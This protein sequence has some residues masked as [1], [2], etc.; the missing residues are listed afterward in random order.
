MSKDSDI[1]KIGFDYRSSLEQFE[2]ETNGVFDEVSNRAG[3]Q[4]IV[5]QLDAKDDKLVE[6]IKELQ[7]LKLDKFTFEFG[8]SGLKEQLQTFDRLEG[9]I[10]EIIKLSK[11]NLKSAFNDVKN[12]ASLDGLSYGTDEYNNELKRVTSSIVEMGKKG[13]DSTRE[14]F[15]EVQKLLNLYELFRKRA[16]GN[17]FNKNMPQANKFNEFIKNSQ[18][19]NDLDPLKDTT[20]DIFNGCLVILD[21]FVD[22]STKKFLSLKDVI[23]KVISVGEELKSIADINVG[24]DNDINPIIDQQGNLQDE[25]KETETQAEKTSQAVKEVAAATTSTDQK[26][27]AFPDSSTNT[28]PETEGMEQVEK[29]TEEAVQAKKDFATANEGVQSSID[30]SE[31]PLKLEAELMDQIAKSARE[32]ADAKKEFVAAN[33]QVKEGA[34]DSTPALKNE[35]D[36]LENIESITPKTD[37]FDEI[38]QKLGI[39]K[40]RAEQ[41]E[42]IVENTQYSK[43]D[44]KSHTSYDI[45]YKGGYKETRGENSQT[46]RGNILKSSGVEY[47]SKAEAEAAKQELELKKKINDEIAEQTAA[48]QKKWQTFVQEQNDYE[49]SINQINIALSKTDDLLANLPVPKELEQIYSKLI[50][51]VELYNEKLKTGKIK[52]PEYNKNVNSLFSDYSKNVN[53]QQKRDVESYNTNAKEAYEKEKL[54]QAEKKLA[55]LKKE[56][57]KKEK[58][59][60]QSSVNKAL[61][62]QETAW[63]NIQDIR[64]KIANSNDNN[65]IEVLE[66]VKK[67]YQEQ[68]LA[69]SRIL[70]ANSDLYDKELQL[71]R[72]E[73][74]RLDTNKKLAVTN[75]N[76]EKIRRK[77]I[78][79]TDSASDKLKKAIKDNSYADASDIK[80][81]EDLIEKLNLGWANFDRK[82]DRSVPTLEQVNLTIKAIENKVDA[83]VSKLKT[84]SKFN[85]KALNNEIKQ[86]T[87][88]ENKNKKAVK[89]EWE[90]AVKA[91][92][93]YENA[94][95]K[96]NNLKAQDKGLGTKKEDIEAQQKKIKDMESSFEV[97]RNTILSFFSSIEKFNTLPTNSIKEVSDVLKLIG[98]AAQGS[99]ESVAHLESETRKMNENVISRHTDKLSS[100]LNKKDG[101]DATIAKFDNGGWTSPEYLKNVQAVKDAIREYEILLNKIKTDQN[102]IANEEDIQN[103]E[104]YKSQIEETIATVKNMSASEKGYTLLAGQKEIDKINKIL[105]ENSKMSRE[106]K[107][108]IKAY[109]QEIVSGNPSASLEKIHGEIMKIVNAEELAGR[110]GKSMLDTIGEKAWYGVASTIGTYFGINDIFRY[111]KQAVDVITEL[112]DALVD[113]KKT[114]TMS[115]TELNNFYYDSNDVA[116]QMGV[117]TEEII[118]QASAWSRLGYSSQE[119]ATTMAKLSSK[120]ASI[121]PGMS[122]DEAQEGLVSIMKAFDIDP[123]DVEA[124]IMD[125]VN[126]LGNK[127]AEENQDVIEGLK[128]SAAAMSAMGQSFTDTAALFTGGM[129]ILQ[130][131]ESMGTA[132]RTLSMRVRGYDEETEQLSDDLAN[133]TGEVADLTKTAKDSQ[134][135]SLFTDATQEHYRS[136]VEYLGDIADRWDQI[137]E[138][139]QTELLQKLFG[140][141]RANAGAAIIKNFDQVRAAIE[142]MYKSAG[143]SETEMSTIEKSISYKINA[144]KETWVGTVQELVDRGDIGK[145]V[146]GLTKISEVLGL[147]INNVGILGSVGLGAGI[148]AG[149]KN[150]GIDTLVAY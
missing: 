133:V 1:I 79:Y 143:S 53:I 55:A 100:Y 26:K 27:D 16:D 120:F 59:S 72:L 66:Q 91:V 121:S 13:H 6:K 116:K 147:I 128:R 145:I 22:V 112:D 146:D 39:A 44:K 71:A 123:D 85:E 139:N 109:K 42:K 34:D 113:L 38:V 90:D 56:N 47:D 144:L 114:T 70:K 60:Q 105:K 51:D 62:D 61:K 43:T 36:I 126:V 40:D 87:A 92:R 136:M 64:E 131:S 8:D 45:T 102:G 142:A 93:E 107:N 17:L 25:L 94:V 54:I 86:E 75:T 3:K 80:E 35:S 52:E 77:A 110:S 57:R 63:K 37:R 150:V 19:T 21:N 99:A 12:A 134:G 18:L 82:L 31:N 11:S 83:V 30:G 10:N 132:L 111:G 149:I 125:K 130:D 117:T 108:K 29:A 89:A 46:D 41:I 48:Q 148:F 129:E 124:E 32:A 98:T 97:A 33:K 104:K 69:A 88:E 74:I 73:Q 84:H 9:K 101:Y 28:K 49:N 76:E 2:K 118:T 115:G 138:K 67:G 122:T 106:A 103:L 65:E 20:S 140:K 119:A 24:K 127:F 81:A 137:S 68:Y 141:N 58:D 5:I 4:K 23:E 96:L 50:D 15:I 7:K 14:Y 78:N 135:V 95:T